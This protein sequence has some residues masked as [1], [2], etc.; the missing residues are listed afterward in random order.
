M[1]DAQ[2]TTTRWTVVLAA[3]AREAP[4]SGDALARLCETYWYPLYVFVRRSGHD[5]Q[6]A[7]DITQG[8]FLRLLEADYLQNVRQEA[9]RFR[10]FLL[11]SIKHY[12]ANRRRDA[13]ALK[14]GG[15]Q[16]QL[17]L[18]A[19][20]AEARF[21][22][23]PRHERTPD[24][25]YERQWARAI[26]QR[27]HRRLRE[28]LEQAGKPEHYRLLSRFLSGGQGSEYEEVA[29]E[30]GSSASAVKMSVSRMRKRFGGILRDE[31]SLTV[32]QD[33]QVDAEVRHL[34]TVFRG[35]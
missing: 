27:A 21:R 25:E 20:Q 35:D 13:A 17:S 32:E 23:E 1:A 2:F 4:G 16:P 34:M 12:M 29:A 10:S 24:R 26:I 3:R 30:M 5:A 19:E 14:R 31:V 28:E 11:S 15:G 33:D 18:D 7:R 6:E 22:L 8:Y 9:G